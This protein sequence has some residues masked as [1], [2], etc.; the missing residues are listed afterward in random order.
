MA[1]FIR[2]TSLCILI[3][4]LFSVARIPTA[5]NLLAQSKSKEKDNNNPEIGL[6]PLSTNKVGV[7][8]CRN[9]HSRGR[10]ESDPKLNQLLS[11]FV[12]QD[13][14][15]IWEK[16]DLHSYS[17]ECLSNDLGRR[18]NQNL[19]W[20]IDVKNAPACLVCHAVDLAP[21]H[22]LKMDLSVND[23]FYSDFGN[24]C[25]GC[26]GLAKEWMIPHSIPTWR[27]KS[28]LEKEKL[29]LIDLRNPTTRTQKCASCHIGN[30]SM[31]RVVTHEMYAAGH[32][33]LIPF[34]LNAFAENEPNHWNLNRDNQFLLQLGEG[35][36][37]FNFLNESGKGKAPDSTQ[38]MKIAKDNYYVISGESKTIKDWAIGSLSSL[39]HWTKLINEEAK[40]SD[41]NHQLMD[42]AHFDCYS[43]HHDLKVPS[44]RQQRGYNG[45]P[46][47]P[48]LK[49]SYIL[50]VRIILSVLDK[51]N[52]ANSENKLL[53]EFNEKIRSLNLSAGT[54]AFGNPKKMIQA[55]ETINEFLE[56]R[57]KDV[58]AI[59]FN[60]D[61]CEKFLLEVNETIGK[62][63]QKEAGELAYL[64]YESAQLLSWAALNLVAECQHFQSNKIP[65]GLV[66]GLK[67][68]QP[69]L[70]NPAKGI[71]LTHL[72]DPQLDGFKSIQERL[73]DRL[74]TLG[75]YSGTNFRKAFD[76]SAPPKK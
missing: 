30:S 34:E 39:N 67:K 71:V 66:E 75:N 56:K 57:I 31:G 35:K 74:K 9:C 50:P 21:S 70:A 4:G 55:T 1:I 5:Q 6:S 43:C 73:K 44:E 53:T 47:R 7:T 17:Y 22:G 3:I 10:V 24:S 40:I 16:N 46:G 27:G 12:K 48:L 32:P 42:F 37:G 20:K 14:C 60:K 23:R 69:D 58:E 54:G 36:I 64:D 51:N 59:S 11:T 41:T 15:N 33:P 19:G 52:K 28:P 29:G 72:R 38:Q 25:E 8:L 62:I 63:A 68:L 49:S 61:L 26:H 76:L 45:I 13:E 18:M 65:P 2:Y